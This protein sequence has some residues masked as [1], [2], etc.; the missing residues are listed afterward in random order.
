MPTSVDRPSQDMTAGENPPLKLYP[1]PKQEPNPALHTKSISKHDCPEH[2]TKTHQIFQIKAAGEAQPGP[3]PKTTEFMIKD[4]RQ[5]CR[6]IASFGSK[7]E[8]TAKM[9]IDDLR[10]CHT[11]PKNAFRHRS[12]IA[13]LHKLQNQVV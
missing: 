8:A 1:V 5:A 7:N 12:G 13:Q 10:I 6:A 2:G 4:S 11:W 3:K 9:A